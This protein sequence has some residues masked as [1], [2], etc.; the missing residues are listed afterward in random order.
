MSTT[1]NNVSTI[2]VLASVRNFDINPNKDG[3]DK[4]RLNLTKTDGEVVS[5]TFT[6]PT[7]TYQWMKGLASKGLTAKFQLELN[8]EGFKILKTDLPAYAK[9]ADLASSFSLIPTF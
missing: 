2:T 4:V 7:A 5:Y 3:I 1:V 8:P 9:P 6:A